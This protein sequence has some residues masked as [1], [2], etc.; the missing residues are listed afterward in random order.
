[1]VLLFIYHLLV[2]FIIYIYIYIIFFIFI[3]LINY[4]FILGNYNNLIND[5]LFPS[6]FIKITTQI[7]F[8]I[9]SL[10]RILNSYWTYLIYKSVTK[11][12][13]NK[14]E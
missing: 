6:D 13:I 1:M 11:T 3:Y 5:N 4:L 14:K 12:S 7:Q 10:T 2:L 9:C 8:F